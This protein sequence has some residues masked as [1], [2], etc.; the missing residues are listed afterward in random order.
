MR[1][2]NLERLL[3]MYE[4]LLPAEVLHLIE[5]SLHYFKLNVA[6]SRF[7]TKI[8]RAYVAAVEQ[9]NKLDYSM[10][11]VSSLL[12]RSHNS[13]ISAH[14]IQMPAPRKDRFEGYPRS[15]QPKLKLR[16]PPRPNKHR[17]AGQV[18]PVL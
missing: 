3:D 16:P 6:I 13:F 1:V 14:L 4:D 12:F 11:K 8:V 17:P 10:P 2:S 18:T 15:A 5:G 9:Y 7:N